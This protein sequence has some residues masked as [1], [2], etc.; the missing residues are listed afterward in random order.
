MGAI[1]KEYGQVEL[2]GVW[3]WE[4][5]PKGA[6]LMGTKWVFVRKTKVD[7]TLDKF[8]ARI[9]VQGFSSIPGV[10][11]FETYAPTASSTT[12]R[13]LFAVGC[14]KDWDIDQMDVS[15][16]FL[17]GELEEEIYCRPPPG[18]EDPQGRVWRLKKSLYGLKQAPR[19]WI[20]TLRS[21]LVKAGFSN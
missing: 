21:V 3:V 2:K 15:G 12:A 19:V 13:L 11:H 17:Y 18:F 4:H 16:A 10:H 7:G 1:I 8:K 5:P 20:H 14:A 9:C 6:K